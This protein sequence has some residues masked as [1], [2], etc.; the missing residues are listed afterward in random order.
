M[1]GAEALASFARAFRAQFINGS[2]NAKAIYFA[3]SVKANVEQIMCVTGERQTPQPGLH[4]QG[5]SRARGPSRPELSDKGDFCAPG[6]SELGKSFA[7][8]L[9]ILLHCDSI[10]IL[11][12]ASAG[13]FSM[14]FQ[15]EKRPRELAKQGK[16][17]QGLI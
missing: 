11:G 3:V 13:V 5:S 12:I 8:D 1:S 15:L 17:K 10:I 4:P 7:T 2:V 14:Y 16:K 6:K 9:D